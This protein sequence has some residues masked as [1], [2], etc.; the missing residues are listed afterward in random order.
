MHFDAIAVIREADDASAQE[1]AI[2][3]VQMDPLLMLEKV[4][5][6]EER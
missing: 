3:S 4:E 6:V 2:G 5:L 1:E